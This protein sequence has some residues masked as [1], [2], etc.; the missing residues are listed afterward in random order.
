MNE[1]RKKWIKMV[2][3]VKMKMWDEFVQEANHKSCWRA[4]KYGKI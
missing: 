4:V 3:D 2:R 1:N